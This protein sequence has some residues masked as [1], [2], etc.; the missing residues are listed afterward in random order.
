MQVK[1]LCIR[2]IFL[3]CQSQQVVGGYTIESGKD[4]DIKRAD[5]LIIVCFIVSKRGPG[6]SRGFCKLL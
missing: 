5:V 3:F 6:Q 4:S 2:V 1:D